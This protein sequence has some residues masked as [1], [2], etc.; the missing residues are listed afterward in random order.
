MAV[1]QIEYNENLIKAGTSFQ[2]FT[3]NH[4]SYLKNIIQIDILYGTWNRTCDEWPAIRYPT[5]GGDRSGI[6]EE[7]MTITI[8]NISGNLVAKKVSN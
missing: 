3:E 2:E 6:S 4:G 8:E 7:N 5:D 1:E